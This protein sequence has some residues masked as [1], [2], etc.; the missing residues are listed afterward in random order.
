MDTNYIYYYTYDLY[1]KINT[2]IILNV[3]INCKIK[4]NQIP[5][6]NRT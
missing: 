4:S 3:R 2:E 6:I 5:T 1:I